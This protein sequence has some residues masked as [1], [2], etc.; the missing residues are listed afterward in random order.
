[1]S[2]QSF[3]HRTVPVE[4]LC[5]YR[6][7]VGVI[8]A[9]D[10]LNWLPYSR[11]LFSSEGFHIGHWSNLAPPPI[12]A[13]LLCGL[14]FIFCCM[15]ALGVYTKSIILLTWFLLAY[16]IGIDSIYEK[17]V[18]T[19]HLVVLAFLLLSDCSAKFSL[20]RFLSK[21]HR[22]P[23]DKSTTCIFAQRLL[24]VYFAQ[25]YFFCALVKMMNPQWVY[26]QALL[27]ILQG[28]WS[29]DW[30]VWFTGWLPPLFIRGVCLGVFLFEIL[31]PFLL[32]VA[33]ARRWMIAL[34]VVFHLANHLLLNIETLSFHFVWALLILYPESGHVAKTVREMRRSLMERKEIRNMLKYAERVRMAREMD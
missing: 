20:D 34:G 9:D 6:I 28:R 3:W 24:Q 26:Q 31:A 21:R 7:G 22:P 29:N 27:L 1:M 30:G 16:L 19:I 11:E 8:I 17:A 12:L 25:T 5:I 15:I 32:F 10:V 23:E 14:L 33:G 13:F 18:F 4:T 2:N